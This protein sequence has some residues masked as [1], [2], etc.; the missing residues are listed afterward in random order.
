MDLKFVGAEGA[1]AQSAVNTASA[2]AA[3]G[4]R[5]AEVQSKGKHCDNAFRLDI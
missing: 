2:G 4:G 1:V 5:N 3:R